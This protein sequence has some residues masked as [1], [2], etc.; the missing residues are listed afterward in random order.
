MRADGRKKQ[1]RTGKRGRKVEEEGGINRVQR[2]GKIRSRV[3]R[4]SEGSDEGKK[5]RE[6]KVELNRK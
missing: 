3:N 1:K 5:A 4:E 2:R 6:G